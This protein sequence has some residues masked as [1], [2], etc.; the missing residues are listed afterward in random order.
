MKSKRK[1][2]HISQKTKEIVFNRDNGR[3]VVC[4]N[5]YNVMPHITL[6]EQ[7]WFR[8]TKYCDFLIL[9]KINVIINMTLGT[10][11]EKKIKK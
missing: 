9:L 2:K 6:V 3:C 4:G 10:K 1:L 8:N 11:E 7:R 5:N